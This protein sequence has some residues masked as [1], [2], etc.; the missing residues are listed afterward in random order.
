MTRS[1]LVVEGIDDLHL[2]SGLFKQVGPELTRHGNPYIEIAGSV[3]KLLENVRDQMTAPAPVIGWV[4]DADFPDD[5]GFAARWQSIRDRMRKGLQD[6]GGEESVVPDML[7]AHGLCIDFS[8]PNG[9]L[10]RG[11]FLW[12]NNGGDGMLETVLKDAATGQASLR[13][14]A[15]ACATEARTEHK[16][17]F[18]P[19][20]QDKAHWR[21][22][23]AWQ[24]N[25]G[26]GYGVAV[27]RGHIDCNHEGLQLFVRWFKD[28]YKLP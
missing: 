12:P 14:Y 27:E 8:T 6:Q 10:R 2:V 1:F 24:K 26:Q 21:T 19:V 17:E 28:L 23:M 13:E 22:L 3:E 16:A 18:S 15:G 9:L 20:H 4:L 5:G 7:P 11:V 25:P